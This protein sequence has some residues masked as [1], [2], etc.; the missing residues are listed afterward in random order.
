M[1]KIVSNSK[2]IDTLICY[3][4]IALDSEDDMMETVILTRQKNTLTPPQVS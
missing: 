2:S 4:L 1:E 3:N